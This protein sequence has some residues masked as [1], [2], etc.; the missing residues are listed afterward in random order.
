MFRDTQTMWGG[1]LQG[2]YHAGDTFR[3]TWRV[4]G[5]PETITFDMYWNM[6][7]RGGLAN[8]CVVKPVKKRWSS[9]PDIYDE[10]WE[11][12][13]KIIKRKDTEFE[14]AVKRLI[15]EFDFFG[16]CR[17]LDECQR[18]GQYGAILI[19]AKESRAL[20]PEQLKTTPL[21]AA[22]G[23]DSLLDL[24]PCMESQIDFSDAQLDKDYSSKRYNLP[25][26]FRYKEGTGV[27]GSRV[28]T[29][30][31]IDQEI[32]Y[33]RAFVFSEFARGNGFIGHSVLMPIFN[34]LMDWYKICGS[35]AEG[36]YKNAKQR[37]NMNITDPS[38]AKIMMATDDPSGAQ[39]AYGKQMTDF[40]R[41]FNNVLDTA[42]VE[43]KVLQAAMADPTGP[44]GVALQDIC[45]N[46]APKTELIGFETGERSSTENANAYNVE[47]QGWRT[48]KGTKLIVNALQ[49]LVDVGILPPPKQR[50]MVDWPDL[51]A[52]SDEQR[53]DNASKLATAVKALADSNQQSAADSI[54]QNLMPDV[55]DIEIDVEPEDNPDDAVDD[56]QGVDD[57]DDTNPQAE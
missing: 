30:A 2:G 26:S 51:S 15:D 16:V 53:I 34:S 41:G 20:S 12:D 6:Y 52:A 5:Y 28:G 44:A 45:S 55:L 43:A 13:G 48:T 1:V 33:S 21:R 42:G 47:N 54:T 36:F 25:L 38:L 31:T 11:E 50:I 40:D 27:I 17:E 49:Q 29:N 32:H 4:F 37:L 23:I 39:E 35:A 10:P 7:L 14:A 19:R 3:N 57:G 24:T 8:A 18:V 22:N 46:I 56:A 9:Y